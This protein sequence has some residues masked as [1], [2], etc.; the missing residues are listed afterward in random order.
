MAERFRT[1]TGYLERHGLRHIFQPGEDS[2]AFD[3]RLAKVTFPPPVRVRLVRRRS[4]VRDGERGT[5][6]DASRTAAKQRVRPA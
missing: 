4:T 2:S 3:E 1:F 6:L 5:W